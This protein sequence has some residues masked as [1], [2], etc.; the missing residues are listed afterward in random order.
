[1][2]GAHDAG[3]DLRDARRLRE[4]VNGYQ[5]SHAISAAATLRLSDLLASGPRTVAD[6]AAATGTHAPTLER[7]LRALTSVGVYD[8]GDDGRFALTG[9]G[10]ALRSD[11]PGSVAAWAELIGR[12]YYQQAWAGLAD[13]VRAGDNAFA[14]LNGMSIWEYRA[15]RP[16][17]LEVFDRAMTSLSSAVAAAV[18]ESYDFGR[19]GT[20]VD[21]G[22]GRG[23]LLTAVV[24]RYPA[25]HGVLFDQ[26]GVV[27][28]A[29]L[30]AGCRAVA[31]DF[32]ESVPEGGDA[33]LL[34]AVLHDWADDE[35]VAVLRSV[36][37]AVP[38]HGSVL[39]VE[40]LL[41]AAPDPVRTAFS[42]LNMLVAPGGRER[43]TDEYGALLSTAGFRLVRAVP[44]GT[45]VFVLEGEPA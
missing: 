10:E 39:I 35:S 1:V 13:S 27:A 14:R 45:D 42:D 41:D 23:S 8:R 5:V 6:L 4:M 29:D 2:I 15:S 19:F 21:V 25:V 18:V 16:E 33:Y 30:P 9:L 22:G 7:L 11:V 34:K 20:V 36:R 43:T 26:P 31:G 38:Q 28:G 12:P 37:R 44:T 17:E 24:A 3:M 40:Q 32:F